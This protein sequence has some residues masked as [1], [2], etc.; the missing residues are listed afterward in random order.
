MGAVIPLQGGIA[1]DLR[2]M[3]AS[4]EV[5]PAERLARLQPGV[6]LADL[7][8]EAER[9]G[10]MLGHDPWNVP[11]ATV[12]GAIST[13]SVGYRASKYGSMGQQVRALEVV[14][15]GGEVVR[16]RPP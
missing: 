16:T 1:L 13:H 4:V 10:L 2:G 14:L 15:A 5:L 9:H 12:G 11:I 7:E 3:D 6:V 8:R